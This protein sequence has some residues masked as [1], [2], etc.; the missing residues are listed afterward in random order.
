MQ[1][2]GYT[3]K[4]MILNSKSSKPEY[5]NVKAMAFSLFEVLIAV[6]VLS[7]LIAALMPTLRSAHERAR[8]I[9]CL[10]NQR[11]ILTAMIHYSS[12][13]NGYL[14]TQAKSTFPYTDWSARLTNYLS[15]NW[16]LANPN[17]R[18][19][20]TCPSDRNGRKT[21]TAPYSWKR[22]WR[23]YAVN[24]QNAWSAGYNI[25]WP[26]PE[27][28]PMKLA[29]VP[30]RVILIGENHGIDGAT[31]AGN[32]GAYMEVS[33]MESLQ[34][35]ASANHRDVGPLGVASTDNSNGGGNY[36]YPDGRVEFHYRTELMNETHVGIF[37]GGDNDPW[38]WL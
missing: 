13:Y 34:G 31:V 17:P 28:T 11:Q 12:D 2:M 24:G 26:A 14:P 7:V 16:T 30:S 35:H 18:C 37:N 9:E 27:E 36:G 3:F 6:S 20:L 8:R 10:S 4:R 22:F 5:L 29:R 23:S 21:G 32:S 33:E 19:V 25:P 1:V 15:W 38:K